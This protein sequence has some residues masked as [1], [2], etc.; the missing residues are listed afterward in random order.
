VVFWAELRRRNVVRV[1]AVY[2]ASGWLVSQVGD[3]V[4]Q[5][6]DAP[7]WP[8]RM[9]LVLLAVGFPVALIVAW[10]FEL[11]PDGLKLTDQVAP[12]ASTAHETGRSLDRVLVLMIGILIVVLV[13]DRWLLP[14][15]GAAPAA[16]QATELAPLAAGPSATPV[17][18]AG[19]ATARQRLANSVAVLPFEN[20]SPRQE[21]AYF[22]AGIHEEILN[23]LAKLRSLNVIARTSMARYANTEKSIREIADELNVETVMEGSVRYAGDRVRVTTQLIDADSG[24]HLWSEAYE[25]DFEDIFA[26]QADIAMS[27]ANALNA[28]FSPEEQRQIERRPTVDPGAYALYL[29][30]SDIASRGNQGPQMEA[31]LDQIIARDPE[32]A[33]AYGFKAN[34]YANLL[35][36]TTYGSAGDMAR[37][38]GLARENAARA[39]ALEPNDA[40]ANSAL[41]L[42]DVFQWRWAEARDRY[43]RQ[44]R[45][46][47]RPPTYYH[48]FQSW[49][50]RRT[51]AIESAERS[52]ALNPLDWASHWFLGIVSLYAGEHDAAAAAFRRGIELAPTLSL[53]HAW[54]A[55]AEIARGNSEV[56]F[57]ELRLAEELLGT[58][59]VIISL[60]DI[61]YGYGRIG[62][63][64]DAERLFAEVQQQSAT[65]EIGAGG[66]ASAYLA[67]GDQARA[68]EWLRVGAERAREKKLD[69][70][71][72]TLMNIRMNPTAD[73]VLE[74]PEFVAVREALTGD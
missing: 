19:P 8:M 25:R 44:Y 33:A 65:Q 68:L 4:A 1:G 31:L 20:L 69:Q 26:I 72:F 54:L 7:G 55:E 16:V 74:Q 27:V 70:G 41:V 34:L 59:R 14:A 30:V 45:E 40:A 15:P 17:S 42:V 29:H 2:L 35:I 11:T 62:R 21:D 46:T 71:F 51:E 5:A 50:G 32:Y 22:A 60:L 13:V 67:I 37:M 73:P 58:N 39:L 52:V 61:L 23:Y 66:W 6:F 12:E 18:P 49:T 9:L 63:G 53:Q 3:I 36:N 57:N 43:E 38:E 48:W 47:G 24:A 56:A 64:A 10:L 28:T